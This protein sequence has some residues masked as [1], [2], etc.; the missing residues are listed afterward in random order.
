MAPNSSFDLSQSTSM[1]K[2]MTNQVVS[3]P[4][5]RWIR[6][7]FACALAAAAVSGVGCRKPPSPSV[8]INGRTWTVELALTEPQRSRGLSGRNT[9]DE[10]AGMLFLFPRPRVLQFWMYQCRFPIDIAFLD[11]KGTVIKTYTMEVEDD[12]ESPNIKTYPSVAAAQ[13]ALELRVGQLKKAGVKEGDVAVFS[14]AIP[15]PA[16]ADP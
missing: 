11:A 8:S 1:I 2:G 7:L 16:K 3:S 15:S 9:L 13:Y 6:P 5:Q 10:D 4:R 14:P 12:P